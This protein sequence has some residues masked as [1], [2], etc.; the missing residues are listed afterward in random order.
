M[1]SVFEGVEVR[2]GRG[3][4]V[5]VLRQEVATDAQIVQRFL[6]EAET[7][8]KIQHPNIVQ[9][10]ESGQEPDGSLYIVQELL[11]GGDLR[12]RMVEGQRMTVRDAFDIAMPIM[13]ALVVAHERGVL[14]R[15]IKPENIFLT[16]GSS[17][18]TVPKLIDF[19][20]SK[21]MGKRSVENLRLT[22]SGIPIGTPFYMSPEQARA[23]DDLNGQADVWSVAVVIYEMIAGRCPHQEANLGLLMY[24]ILSE[25]VPR[26]EQFAPQVPPDVAGLLH[27]ALESDRTR[28][29][30]SMLHFVDAVLRCPSLAARAGEADL[31]QRFKNS[32][33]GMRPASMRQPIDAFAKTLDPTGGS[34]GGG[35][36]GGGGGHIGEQFNPSKT[37]PFLLTPGG[38]GMKREIDI[39]LGRVRIGTGESQGRVSEPSP[40]PRA[41]LESTLPGPAHKNPQAQ[42]RVLA[43]SEPVRSPFESTLPGPAEQAL[44]AKRSIAPSLAATRPDLALDQ[45]EAAP[46][47][48]RA[49]IPPSQDAAY[50][51]GPTASVPP[52]G[53]AD[54]E[55]PVVLPQ[56][57]PWVPVLLLTIVLSGGA[58]LAFLR[59]RGHTDTG[60]AGGTQTPVAVV[61][62]SSARPVTAD[63]GAT[64]AT[65]AGDAAA[66]TDATAVRSLATT[67]A[68][69]RAADASTR[70]AHSPPPAPRRPAGTAPRTPP[71]GAIGNI[72]DPSLLHPTDAP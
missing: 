4:A 21:L 34:G 55:Q 44:R 25:P 17:G 26:I 6:L 45:T 62:A 54:L 52:P 51:L 47:P 50:T 56:N 29:I 11:S 15:D 12:S 3:V 49:S 35:G 24:K 18:S 72:V 5:K 66:M 36:P 8:A 53:G 2:T 57:F 27:H 28:R 64:A 39:A 19:G 30:P 14:H 63:A 46:M 42:P 60:A 71:G 68:S 69:T 1:G 43:A 70:A 38:P 10:I 48:G 9:L 32:L 40:P 37:V 31:A 22:R 61:D 58:T 59:L 33:S 13:G 7:L 16:R 67:D 41:S 65:V 23:E 20:L